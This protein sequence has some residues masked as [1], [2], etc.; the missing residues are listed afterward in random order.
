MFPIIING[1]HLDEAIEPAADA[2]G[3]N[4]ILVQS[5]AGLSPPQKQDL[6]KAGVMVHDYVSKNTYLCYFEDSDLDRLR[7][8]E[9]FVYVD[10]Y[11]AQF[12]VSSASPPPPTSLGRKIKLDLIFHKDVNSESQTLQDLVATASGVYRR[13]IRFCPHKAR[14]EVDDSRLRQIEQIDEVRR[15]EEVG[16]IVLWNNTA[17]PILGCDNQQ[18]LCAV[19]GRAY[20]GDGQVIAVADTGLD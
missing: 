9:P 4:Y 14:L 20:Q 16:E 1:N 3:T 2:S 19:Q 5:R 7:Q 10:V 6:A 15:I 18:P 12:K 11:R 8:M 17:R 13:Y